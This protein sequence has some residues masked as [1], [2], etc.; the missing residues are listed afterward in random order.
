MQN[1]VRFAILNEP[2]KGEMSRGNF[3]E[4]KNKFLARRFKVIRVLIVKSFSCIRLYVSLTLLS[5]CLSCAVIGTG[6]SD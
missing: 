5:H 1:D 6:I 4:I 2:F 3:L